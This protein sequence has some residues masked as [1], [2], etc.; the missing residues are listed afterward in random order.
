MRRHQC[1]ERFGACWRGS[2]PRHRDASGHR[3]RGNTGPAAF[4]AGRGAGLGGGDPRPRARALVP[5]A[6]SA[7]SWCSLP[8]A[9]AVTGTRKCGPQAKNRRAGAP[10]GAPPAREVNERPMRRTALRPP[11]T[12]FEG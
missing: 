11:R 10:R 4:E 3:P 9:A 8:D 6:M 1:G 12:S 7:S 5:R 2:Q